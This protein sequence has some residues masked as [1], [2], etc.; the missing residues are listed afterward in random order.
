MA[1]ALRRRA[2]RLVGPSR[3]EG[4]ERRGVQVR[5]IFLMVVLVTMPSLAAAQT[6]GGDAEYFDISRLMTQQGWDIA[7]CCV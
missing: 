5:S 1:R 7:K 6:V 4:E 3:R 2:V